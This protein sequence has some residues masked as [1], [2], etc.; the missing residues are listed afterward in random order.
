MNN[1]YKTLVLDCFKKH[2]PQV[3]LILFLVVLAKITVIGLPFLL[4]LIV[5]EIPEYQSHRIESELIYLPL[6]AIAYASFFLATT[7]FDEAKEYLSEKLIQPIVAKVGANAF[8]KLIN[9][10]DDY[11][12]S[13]KSGA[14]MRDIDR[15]LKGLQS[16]STLFIHTIIP[17]FFELLFI[18]IFCF[19][20]YDIW[21]S[22]TIIIGLIIH[23]FITLIGSEKLS[24]EKIKLN[25]VDS[26]SAALLGEAVT[27]SETIKLFSAEKHETAKFLGALNAYSSHAI[28]FQF[29]HAKL[30]ALQQTVI[31][32]ILGILL[33]RASFLAMNNQMTAGEFV[34]LAALAM[35]VLL[36]ISFLGSIWKEAMRLFA[37][38]SKLSELLK[39]PS[40]SYKS[41]SNI[42][43][44]SDLPP[45]IMFKGVTFGYGDGANV[46]NNVTF[47]IPSGGLVAL[48]GASGSGKTTITKLFLG[49]IEPKSGEI[50]INGTT[51]TQQDRRDF[52][53]FVG[54]VP[55]NVTLF[56]GTIASNIAYGKR[57]ASI[58]EIK[59]AAQM[60]QMDSFI[61]MLPEGYSTQVGER[62]LK[63][64]GGERQ[65][66]GIARALIN[67]PKL[68][69]LDEASSALD[70]LS[71]SRFV[72][73][74]L[75]ARQGRTCLV[76]AHR[77]SMVTQADL[78]LVL[79][80][81]AIVES[82]THISLLEKR[83]N[84]AALWAAQNSA[85]F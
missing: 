61:A 31:A 15:G 78:I 5:D 24:K 68:L 23:G 74:A 6:L 66:L 21:I 75:T 82:G 17:T 59:A 76:I 81:G 53:E 43:K 22:A 26:A 49:F 72:E 36:P 60:A 48:V 69:I 13:N 64:S 73:S 83:G 51:T 57:D 54:V 79:N 37:D 29:L 32:V 11:L 85:L 16:L 58:V 33:V 20:T 45:S 63:L 55:Q 14:V 18:T 7:L 80:N 38:V 40:I 39:Y 84:Y 25:E 8:D 28:R 44:I 10:P 71:E 46:V 2:G 50:Q 3:L 56:H 42:G 62:G 47:S 4:K 27:N 41:E 35:Q 77:L 67:N 65:M 70:S 30:R 9:L 19:F 52:R 12:I 1:F 34:L